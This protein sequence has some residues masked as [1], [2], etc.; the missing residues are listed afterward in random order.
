LSGKLGLFICL[1]GYGCDSAIAVNY[2]VYRDEL[3]LQ[4]TN[5]I[6]SFVGGLGLHPN[7]SL[8]TLDVNKDVSGE[9]LPSPN[10]LSLPQKINE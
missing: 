1:P 2:S 10:A 6:P 5:G 3:G 9:V 4:P 7:S 8:F